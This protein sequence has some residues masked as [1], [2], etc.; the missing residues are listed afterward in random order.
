MAFSP[1][2][3]R[4]ASAGADGAVRIW[5]VRSHA[6]LD[7][8]TAA[9]VRSVLFVKFSPDGQRLAFLDN[10]G[11]IYL[12]EPET[13][14]PP[15]PFQAHP[16]GS[17]GDQLVFSPDGRRLASAS[18]DESDAKI[19]DATTGGL[20]ASYPGPGENLA[21]VAFSPDGRLLAVGSGLH[22]HRENGVVRIW[23]TQ[24]NQE[25]HTLRGHV[26]MTGSLAF[27]PDCRRLA[28]TSLDQTIKI[29]DMQTG[30]EVLT[31]TG[32][33]SAVWSGVFAPDG[34]LFS[35]GEDGIRVWD[36]RP[37]RE[38]EKGQEFLT[39]EGHRES[40]T[41]VAF[42][43]TGGLLATGDCVGVVKLWSAPKPQVGGVTL[44]RPLR[45]SDQ[46][47][48][49]LAFSPDDKVLATVGGLGL[50]KLWEASTGREICNLSNSRDEGNF[51]T[52][53]FSPDG[54]HLAAGGWMT[55]QRTKIWNLQTKEVIQLPPHDL[56]INALA[57]HPKEGTF[58]VT[59]GEDG[60]VRVWDWRIGKELRQ[61]Q[62]PEGSR[63]RSVAFSPD[64]KLLAAGGWERKVHIWDSTGRDPTD[65][66][67]IQ[68][69]PDSTG[70]PESIAFSPDGRRLAW[71]GTDSTVKVWDLLSKETRI[72]HGH[73]NWVRSVAFSSDG[74]FIASGGQDGIVKIWE[75][76]A[77]T[78]PAPTA[79]QP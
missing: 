2:G 66:K 19:W 22:G 38:G 39:L 18:S 77:F 71:G 5:D 26:E 79:R 37:W 32:H 16:S 17:E 48:Y 14:K 73:T 60:S 24:S 49:R 6:A 25:L 42:S 11:R 70:S 74:R 46:E 29:W 35:A 12:W 78:Q 56:G 55:D 68:Q 75:T 20:L 36:G 67:H 23:D 28:S 52:V 33:L 13:G 76:P 50:V 3:Q 54:C 30:V 72:L 41:S 1:D 21:G 69:F 53:A 8:W 51:M 9:D 59:A 45:V 58:L 15:K 64:G 57:F 40:V 61:L 4:V 43:S 31:L 63:V 27:S 44:L 7:C 62:P 47:V 65:W 34:R 10:H